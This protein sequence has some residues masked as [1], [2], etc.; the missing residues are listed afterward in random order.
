M[1]A[2]LEITKKDQQAHS[3]NVCPPTLNVCLLIYE[4]SSNKLVDIT[5]FTEQ[6]NETKLN[7]RIL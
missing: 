1:I 5:K 7:M 4:L 3:E 6:K 2:K